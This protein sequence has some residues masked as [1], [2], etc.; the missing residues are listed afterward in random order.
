M[1]IAPSGSR[2]WAKVMVFVGALLAQT[3]IA[4]EDLGS[5]LENQNNLTT[6]TQLIKVRIIRSSALLLTANQSRIIRT[7]CFNYPATPVSR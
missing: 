6:F 2:P 1:M 4:V 7:F 3:V 5:V